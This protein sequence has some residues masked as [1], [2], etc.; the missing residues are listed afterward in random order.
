[1]TF[2]TH[3]SHSIVIRKG[4]SLNCTSFTARKPSDPTAFSSYIPSIHSA[5]VRFLGRIIDG[6]ISDRKCVDE[7]EENLHDGLSLMNKSYFKD[8]HKLW[9]LQHLLIP[10]IQW[11]LLIY[12]LSMPCAITLEIQPPTY[13]K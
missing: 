6:S 4:K 10:R 3:K 2:R 13:E 11:P 12:E 1:M 9:I 5:P 7:L 8:T